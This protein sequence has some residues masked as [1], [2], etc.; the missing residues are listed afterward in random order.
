MKKLI[1]AILLTGCATS[2]PVEEPLD[3]AAPR[4]TPVDNWDEGYDAAQS[5]LLPEI[6]RL[7]DRLDGCDSVT[8]GLFADTV[9]LKAEVNE[10]NNMLYECEVDK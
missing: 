6:D 8:A 9:R 3:T 5:E 1:I 10:I 4:C 2:S 7:M